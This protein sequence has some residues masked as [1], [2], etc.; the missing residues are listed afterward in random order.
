MTCPICGALGNDSGSLQSAFSGRHFSFAR[1]VDCGYGWVTDPREDYDVIYDEKYYSGFGADPGVNYLGQFQGQPDDLLVKIKNVEFE[2]LLSTLATVLEQRYQGPVSK[3]KVLD[4]GGGVGGFVKYL[5]LH[6]VD[7]ELHDEGYGVEFAQSHGV[8]VRR[9]LDDVVALYDVVFAIEV[10][11]HIKDPDQAFE[12]IQRVLKPGGLLLFTT[13]NLARHRGDIASWFYARHPEVHI[14]FFTP[15]AFQRLCA[16]HGLEPL[17]IRFAP[18]AIQYR[19][20]MRLP[21]LKGLAYA[22]R[23][24][25]RP[26]TVVVESRL[27]FS[28]LGAALKKG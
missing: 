3:V 18:G 25:W 1:C 23:S 11:E 4:F 15:E 9:S 7:A 2:A 13:G 24:L 6:G 12:V 28:E 8:R 26:L 5:T 17:L 16:R 22:T 27:G 20:L 19:T 14:S 21:I 10:L